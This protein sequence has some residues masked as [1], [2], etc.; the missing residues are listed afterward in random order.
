MYNNTPHDLHTQQL[1]AFI[2][3]HRNSGTPD[4]AIYGQ[5]LDA[6]WDPNLVNQ[7]LEHTATPVPQPSAEVLASYAQYA[8]THEPSLQ[9]Q[10][11]EAPGSTPSHAQTGMFAGRLNR[12][13]FVLAIAYSIIPLLAA[14]LITFMT[15]LSNTGGASDTLSDSGSGL[16]DMVNLLAIPL[17]IGGVILVI[18]TSFS[19]Y[20][21]RLHD[22]GVSGWWQ[23]VSFIPPIG[24]FMLLYILLWPGQQQTN[25]YGPPAT[26]GY[27]FLGVLGLKK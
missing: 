3:S 19:A 8:Q 1:D 4:H 13:G 22:L 26:H 14:V 25:K 6:G 18:L 7:R 21:R 2:A 5:L 17:G 10:N 23:L 16:S 20:T 12:R 27:G 11:T 9:A 15:V 24:L